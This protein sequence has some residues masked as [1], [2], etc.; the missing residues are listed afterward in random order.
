MYWSESSEW[1]EDDLGNGA[2]DMWMGNRKLGLL[3]LKKRRLRGIL[4][5]V[6]RGRVSKESGARLF[7]VISCERITGNGNKLKHNI[8]RLSIGKM[9]LREF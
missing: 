2:S 5:K 6:V 7:L 4:I 1:H 9:P 3:S 8:F